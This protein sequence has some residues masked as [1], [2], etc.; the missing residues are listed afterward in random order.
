MPK[1]KKLKQNNKKLII[2]KVLCVPI[3]KFL[4]IIKIMQ[5]FDMVYLKNYFARWGNSTPKDD[6]GGL[7]TIFKSII[8]I[9]SDI[10]LIQ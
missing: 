3:T 6:R 1:N 5:K 4:N 10:D 8:K 2:E 9:Q 7:I